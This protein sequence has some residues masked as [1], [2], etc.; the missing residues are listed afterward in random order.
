MHKQHVR[1]VFNRHQ[2]EGSKRRML[3]NTKIKRLGWKPTHTLIESLPEIITGIQQHM[4]D[5]H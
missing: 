1:L 5:N 3:D 2:P 4:H